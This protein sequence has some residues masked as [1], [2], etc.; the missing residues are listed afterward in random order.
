M[1][2][3]RIVALWLVGLASLGHAQGWYV[4][5]SQSFLTLS[6][7]LTGALGFA[8][9]AKLDERWQARGSGNVQVAKTFGLVGL[10]LDGLYAPPEGGY[11]GLGLGLEYA[12]VPALPSN[13]ETTLRAVLGNE[14]MITPYWGV[15]LEALLHHNLNRSL[16]SLDY[17]LGLN[18][19]FIAQNEKHP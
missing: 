3:R 4:G 6:S 14:W 8:V 7:N 18:L 1:W 15:Y 5:A 11:V 16:N 19:Y 10:T 12:I 9:G 13:L 17:R 2:M